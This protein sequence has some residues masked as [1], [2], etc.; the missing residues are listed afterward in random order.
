LQAVGLGGVVAEL[1][2]GGSPLPFLGAQ[3]LL[4]AAPVIDPLVD[5]L[6]GDSTAGPWRSAWLAEWLEN[7]AARE[8]LAHELRAGTR[9][10]G[11]PPA[12]AK[13]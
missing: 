2:D 10:P 9:S 4:F 3:A 12:E 13:S 8:A 1:L 6:A 5:G 11:S 7:P